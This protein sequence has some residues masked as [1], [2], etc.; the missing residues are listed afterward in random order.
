VQN[1][2]LIALSLFAAYCAAATAELFLPASGLAPPPFSDDTIDH[3]YRIKNQAEGKAVDVD[4][5]Q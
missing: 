4:V 2:F 3:E 5:R 1:W